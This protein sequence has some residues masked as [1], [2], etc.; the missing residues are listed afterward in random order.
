MNELSLHPPGAAPK[1]PESDCRALVPAEGPVVVDAFGG[2]VHVEWDP[3]AAVTPLGQLP[4]FTEFLKVS[5]LFDAWVEA[6]PVRW[7]SNN[8]KHS[9]WAIRA[10]VISAT[11]WSLSGGANDFLADYFGADPADSVANLVAI[12]TDLL[13]LG[14]DSLMLANVPPLDQ[15]PEFSGSPAEA[16][17][18]AFS[19]GFD[20]LYRPAVAD[21]RA[22]NPAVDFLYFDVYS[23]MQDVTA[24]PAAFG[25]TSATESLL[26][27]GPVTDPEGYLFWDG[28]HPTAAGHA[29]LARIAARLVPAPPVLLLVLPGVVALLAGRGGA[30]RRSGGARF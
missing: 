11:I 25:F 9:C 20:H 8:F 10:S 19:I 5:G 4:F 22:A 17:A 16:A 24:D 1:P 26:F 14:A 6:C 7:R 27:S 28:V 13:N 30:D 3:S 21:F 12:I 18:A 2:R 15:T 23:T 29:E